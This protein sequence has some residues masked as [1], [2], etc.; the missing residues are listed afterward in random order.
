MTVKLM[1]VRTHHL[2]Q[3]DSTLLCRNE[4]IQ[5]ASK[6]NKNDFKLIRRNENL[7]TI[8]ER[9]TLQHNLAT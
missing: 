6:T 8:T 2:N 7:K 3:C 9:G 4:N 5:V 1:Q